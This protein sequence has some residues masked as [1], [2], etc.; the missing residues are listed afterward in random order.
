MAKKG[1]AEGGAGPVHLVLGEDSYLAE[2]ALERIL[3]DAIGD[4][5]TDALT[6]L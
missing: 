5:R 3:A 2:E 4:D 1:E 6:V